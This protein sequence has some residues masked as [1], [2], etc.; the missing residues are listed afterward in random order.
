MVALAVP[1]NL[2]LGAM[3]YLITP[4]RQAYA[5]GATVRPGTSVKVR[6]MRSNWSLTCIESSAS[7]LSATSMPPVMVR[8]SSCDR[9][10][11]M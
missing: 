1:R 7:D 2:L 6:S 5:P 4:S 8:V 10:S 3:L 11:V 9:R